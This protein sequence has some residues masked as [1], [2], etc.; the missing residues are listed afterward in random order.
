VQ[1]FI[2][3]AMCEYCVDRLRMAEEAFLR[4]EKEAAPARE[5]AAVS[6]AALPG[7]T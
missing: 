6:K 3:S 4:A 2:L 5:T 7:A 1:A